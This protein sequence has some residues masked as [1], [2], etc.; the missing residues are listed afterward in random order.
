[1][2]CYECGTEMDVVVWHGIMY[3]MCPACS[4]WEDFE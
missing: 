3:Y 4:A 1:M 2:R